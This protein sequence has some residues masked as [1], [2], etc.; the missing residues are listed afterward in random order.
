MRANGGVEWLPP[1]TGS[2]FWNPKSSKNEKKSSSSIWPKIWNLNK[3]LFRSSCTMDVSL[4]PFDRQNC[5]L[6]FSSS[7]YDAR[8]LE[9]I[10]ASPVIIDSGAFTQ[11]SE[12]R[13]DG[14][15]GHLS[16]RLGFNPYQMHLFNLLLCIEPFWPHLASFWTTRIETQSTANHFIKWF[17]LFIWLGFRYFIFST[18]LSRLF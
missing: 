10:G 15:P 9:F 12:W 14:C 18:L 16:V 13:L 17:L 2:K 8:D 4:F 3:A 1:V 5:T 11:N 6:I 7:T